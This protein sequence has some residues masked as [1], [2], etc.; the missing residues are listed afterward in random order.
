MA[1]EFPNIPLKK[2]D[3]LLVKSFIGPFILTFFIALFVLVMQFL[4]KYIDDLVG[5]G[6]NGW[7]VFELIFYASARLVPLA[8]PLA[9]LLSSIMTFGSLGEHLE[10]T[11]IK[12]AGISLHRTM[13]P[14]TITV[15][16]ISIGAFIF[17]N[18]YLPK[19]N[20]KF[21]TLLYDIRNQKPTLA[22]KEGIFYNE[23]DG[24]SL[25]V[26]QKENDGVGLKGILLY[27]HSS[28]LGSDHVIYADKGKLLQDEKNMALTL[29]LE[30][31][32]QYKETYT[33]KKP[34][35]EERYDLYYTKFKSWE[36]KFDLSKFKLNRSDENFFKDMKQ[37]LSLNQLQ[38]QRDTIEIEKN[39]L[40]KSMEGYNTPYFSF[41]KFKNDNTPIDTNN[42]VFKSFD[43]IQQW[44]G[45]FTS[46]EQNV[47]HERAMNQARG[48][49]N[50]SD[51]VVNQI[52]FKVR[53]SNL[54]LVEIYRKFT[55]SIAC[56]VL[57]FIGAPLGSIIRKGGLG[58]PLAYSIL[59]FI[60]Y[61]VTSIIG[62]ELAEKMILST[63]HGMW[64]STFF[65]TPIGV[66]L[67]YKAANDSNLFNSDFYRKILYKIFALFSKTKL[68]VAK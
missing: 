7:V 40:Y 5:K 37:M 18:Y 42:I 68:N 59:F 32:R 28:G 14:L 25:R 46:S 52:G 47:M 1:Q 53:E 20:V 54:F 64:F 62:E 16:F 49:K 55:L 35:D 27:D 45:S 65:L 56:I 4:W 38:N 66:F 9:V 13:L 44:I 34:E 26:E 48:V 24:F 31:G 8:L 50:Y 67:T 23:I 51:I 57:F 10:L 33:R 3:W 41:L 63:F 61:H 19:S 29:Y 58:W 43:S 6:L 30:N 36:K 15:V 60:I 22:L 17:A 2:F 12:S 21:S 39:E 11:A